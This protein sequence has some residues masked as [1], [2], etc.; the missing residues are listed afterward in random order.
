MAQRKTMVEQLE[1]EPTQ[2]YIK[3]IVFTEIGS[4]RTMN[5]AFKQFYETTGEVSQA[6]LKLAE[7]Y[8]WEERAS[9]YDKRTE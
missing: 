2:D 5:K 6:W 1:N 8:H 7:K 4:S 3:F 9:N